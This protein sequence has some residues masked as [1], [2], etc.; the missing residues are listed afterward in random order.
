M[1]ILVKYPTRQ[2]PELFLKTLKGYVDKAYDNREISYLISYDEDDITMSDAVLEAAKEFCPNII[3]IKGKSD[4][5]IHACNR[6]IDSVP[7]WE[8]ILLISDDMECALYSWDQE[9]RKYMKYLYPD[10]DGCLWFHD[11]SDQKRISTLSCVGK[12]YYDR[13]GYLYYPEYKSFFCDNE[14]TEIASKLNKIRFINIVL[15][16]H[17]HPAWIKGMPSDDLYKKNDKHWNHDQTLYHRRK[18]INFPTT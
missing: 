6:D 5:K 3:F 13:F 9:I 15:A 18:K 16:Q 10:T 2:R 17:K 12:K 4:S 8:I 11:G 7:D 14:Y 1:K